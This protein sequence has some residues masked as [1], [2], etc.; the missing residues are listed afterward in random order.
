MLR[1][2]PITLCVFVFSAI[3]ACE[4]SSG[5]VKIKGGMTDPAPKTPLTAFLSHADFKSFS[6]LKPLDEPRLIILSVN[7]MHPWAEDYTNQECTTG[8]SGNEGCATTT[9]SA[10]ADDPCLKSQEIKLRVQDKD[11]VII[12]ED[13]PELKKTKECE[14]DTDASQVQT[15]LKLYQKVSC[16][17]V[18]LTEFD[19]KTWGGPDHVL[20]SK[21][22]AAKC[23]AAATI[24]FINSKQQTTK[25]AKNTSVLK[26]GTFNDQGDPCV[27]TKKEQLFEMNS[28][29]TYLSTN[30]P[31]IQSLVIDEKNS[32]PEFKPGDTVQ[33][34]Y[35]AIDLR[36]DTKGSFYSSGSYSVFVNQFTGGIEFSDSRKLPTYKLNFGDKS[37]SG[38]LGLEFFNS[39]SVGGP[40]DGM[41]DTTDTP[42]TDTSGANSMMLT[43]K[44][45][46]KKPSP[47]MLKS[48]LRIH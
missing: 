21:E 40:T 37:F 44:H 10:S 5:V 38:S 33:I 30:D 47:K 28:C 45:S 29:T 14:K 41:T 27:L 20:I 23:M 26:S 32:N 39:S 34:A 9:Q 1:I 43:E 8:P 19:G 6:S 24:S 17:G 36:T 4:K 31:E 25:D 42:A 18:D 48:L 46:G 15:A 2:I 22:I 7:G 16:S 12:S 3:N 35:K 11:T 13:I